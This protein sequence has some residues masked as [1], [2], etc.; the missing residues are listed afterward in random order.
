MYELIEHR[1]LDAAAAS[2]TFNNIPQVF[3]DLVLV[4][5]LRTTNT[6]RTDGWEDVQLSQN[7]STSNISVRQLYGFGSGS[8]GS[9]TSTGGGVFAT[10]A[11]MTSGTF[12]STAMYFTN[13]TSSSTKSFSVESITEQNATSAI[14]LLAAGLISTSSPLTSLGLS[15]AAGGIN[16]AVGSSATLY[17]INRTSG[18]GRAP[19]AMGGYMSYSNG[20]WVHT[21]PSSGSFIPF[22]NMEVEYLVVA[23]GGS[24]GNGAG[25][26]GGAGGYRSSV[27]GEL[28]G[29]AS[30]AEAKLSL[31]ANTNYTV[32]V[33]AGGAA[34]TV[35]DTPGTQGSSSVF[36]TITATG[37]G[38]GAGFSGA[39]G[40][41]G[42]GGGASYNATGGAGTSAQGFDGA[43]AANDNG[44]GGG[45]GSSATARNG[46]SGLASSIT[47]TA[48]F[49][50]G[51]GGGYAG[52]GGNG[53]G[54][55][56]GPNTSTNGTPGTANTGGGGGGT[57][58][59]GRTTGAGGSGIVIVRYK[60]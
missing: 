24:G 38:R 41:G 6:S 28:S 15:P 23:G 31:T 40:S 51:G 37:G 1:R 59:T 52:T 20:Y 35:V 43:G 10:H 55:D 2:I 21:F 29:R 58:G 7:G 57:N 44:G 34:Q 30:A 46:G 56:G 60:A 54:G 47:G 50:A 33:G 8:P 39:G 26:G 45:A 14:A 16:F 9:N 42:S 4:S 5:S 12:S 49:R 17:G 27:V 11:N 22:T 53:G 48:V 25:G 36:S 19:L 18:I 13:Y 32:T 3:T